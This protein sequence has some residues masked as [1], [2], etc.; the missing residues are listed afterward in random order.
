[1]A[2]RE[3]LVTKKSCSHFLKKSSETNTPGTDE[4]SVKIESELY[5]DI[6]VLVQRM[7]D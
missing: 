2:E 1:M 5:S 3:N 6:K 7:L 4:F